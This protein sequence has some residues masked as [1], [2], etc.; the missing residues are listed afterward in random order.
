MYSQLA[1]PSRDDCAATKQSDDAQSPAGKEGTRERRQRL[2]SGCFRGRKLRIGYRGQLLAAK[3]VDSG[4]QGLGVEMS[5]PMEIDSFVSFV[6]LG[7]QGR[8]QVVHCRPSDDGV[9]RAGLKLEAVS[10]RKLDVSSRALPSETVKVHDPRDRLLNAGALG[11]PKGQGTDDLVEGV[12]EVQLGA[13]QDSSEEKSQA[14]VSEPSMFQLAPVSTQEETATDSAGQSSSPDREVQA[15]FSEMAQTISQ[16]VEVALL[17]LEL[18][19]ANEIKGIKQE[20]RDSKLNEILQGWTE[21]Q[22]QIAELKAN[23]SEQQAGLVAAKE[24]LSQLRAETETAQQ[25]QASRVDSI[26][27]RLTVQE[28]ELPKLTDSIEDLSGKLNA[29]VQRLDLIGAAWK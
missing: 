8:A 11:E 9:F 2:R 27:E 25:L 6:G 16:A 14:N 28:A 1:V 15:S 3:V 18:H 12:E 21:T 24:R 4:D 19:R 13:T 20:L 22:Q 5:A 29:V 17:N 23:V 10:F 7:L 26:L